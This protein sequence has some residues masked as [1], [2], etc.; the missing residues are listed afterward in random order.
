MFTRLIEVDLLQE[1]VVVHQ[2]IRLV[3]VG[4]L[5]REVVEEAM[6][7][8]DPKVILREAALD[9]VHEEVLQAPGMVVVEACLEDVAHL[10]LTI[11]PDLTAEVHQ[12]VQGNMKLVVCH[13]FQQ[14]VLH[15]Q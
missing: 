11:L 1:A 7:L 10:E 14:N 13:H 4:T 2:C 5:L 15:S 6:V 12:P 8:Q 3:V 9:L